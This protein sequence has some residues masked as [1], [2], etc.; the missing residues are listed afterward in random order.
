MPITSEDEQY[1][2]PMMKEICETHLS[3]DQDG[4]YAWPVHIDIAAR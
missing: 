1:F 3:K 4:W 2:G